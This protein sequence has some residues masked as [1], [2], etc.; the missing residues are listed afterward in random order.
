MLSVSQQPTTNHSSLEFFTTHT[1]LTEFSCL[2]GISFSQSICCPFPLVQIVFLQVSSSFVNPFGVRD[3]SSSFVNP[4]GS[5]SVP[6]SDTSSR[7]P[8]QSTTNA[9]DY[10]LQSP[11]T[12]GSSD[13]SSTQG[14]SH[15]IYEARS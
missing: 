7:T 4:F 6:S 14:S 11:S 12:Q 2:E 13:G 15:G 3:T 5:D 1:G 10:S 9:N 8:S